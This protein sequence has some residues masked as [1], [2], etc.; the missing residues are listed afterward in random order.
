[1]KLILGVLLLAIICLGT[2]SCQ[3]EFTPGNGDSTFIHP[4]AVSGSFTAKIDGVSFVANKVTGITRALNTIVIA[5]QD[6]NG[7]TI[8]LRVADSGVHVY[9]L[10]INSATNA[11]VYT[12]DSAYAY[13]T[14][15]GSTPAESG[16]TL[17]VTSIDTVHKTMSGTFSVKVFRALDLSQK[18]ITEGVFKNISYTTQAIPPVNANDTFRLKVDGVQFPVFSANGISAFGMISLSASDQSVSKSVGISMP[19]TIIPGTYTFT[20]LGDA[21]GQYNIGT[22]YEAASSGTLTIVEHNTVTKRI[23]GNFNFHASEI[24]GTNA[25]DIT[26]G[27]FS[28]VYQ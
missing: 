28:I 9:S 24:I 13:A 5:G 3:K 27:Y 7:Q 6:T 17:S 22:S 10:D 1:M 11:A 2:Y 14:N 12:K 4:P 23:R 19:A 18:N 21:I 8:V 25:S 16:G 15:Q 26:E 20:V